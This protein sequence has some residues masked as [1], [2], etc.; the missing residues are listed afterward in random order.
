MMS[1]FFFFLSFV[2]VRRFEGTHNR[3]VLTRGGVI[4]VVL[5]SAEQIGSEILNSERPMLKQGYMYKI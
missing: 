5:L 4:A 2:F 3:C 1:F